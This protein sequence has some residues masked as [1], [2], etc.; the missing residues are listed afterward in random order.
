MTTRLKLAL[1]AS[2]ALFA[3]PALAQNQP[4]PPERYTIDANS[5]DLVT[6]QFLYFTQEAGIGSSG[7]G[8]LS[9]QRIYNRGWR[10]LN[11]GNIVV[12]GSTYRVAIGARTEVFTKSG[13][14]FTPKSNTGNTLTQSGGGF[15]Y[16]TSDGAVASFVT[17][18][19]GHMGAYDMG[20]VISTLS[21]PNGEMRT[22]NYREDV[23][24]RERN[25]FSGDCVDEI[26]LARLASITNNRGYALHYR[27]ANDNAQANPIT[28]L[29]FKG[30]ST[31]NRAYPS[32]IGQSASYNQST[33]T[34]VTDQDN[35]TTLYSYGAGNTLTLVR[36]PGETVGTMISYDSFGRVASVSGRQGAWT[37]AYTDTAT[38]RTT[39]ATG[40]LGQKVIVE[41]ALPSGLVST[42]TDALGRTL[43]YEYDAQERPTKITQPEG[44][45]ALLTYDARGNVTQTRYVAKPGTGLA[46][47][48]TSAVYPA[49]CANPVTCNQPTSTTDALGHT[50]NYTYDAAH[51]GVLTITAS[52]PA[53]GAARPQTR[54]AYAPQTGYIASGASWVPAGVPITLPVSVSECTTGT[55]CAGAANEVKTSIVYGAA[56]VANNL[57]PT[58]VTT[59]AGNGSLSATTTMTYTPN[60]DVASVN[61]PLA[62]TADTT[63]YR[64]NLARQLVGVVGPDPDGT[65]PLLR[66][67][68]RYTYNPRGQVTLAEAGT[69]TGTS[70]ANWA[71]FASLQKTAATY[72]AYGR[73]T[74]Q[75]QQ[76]GSTTH[77]L[78]QTSYDAAGRVDCVTTRMN[79]ATFA[80]PPTSACSAGTIGSFGPDRITKYGY[81]AASQLISTVSGF[82][83][84]SAAITERAAYSLNG[85]PISLTDGKGNVT[86]LIY[87]GFDRLA[88]MNYPNAMGGG[89]NI[90]DYELYSYNAA[91][92][93]LTYRNR[94]GNTFTAG[95]D[96]LGRQTSVTGGSMPARAYAYDNLG[97]LTSASITAG[98]SMT[99]T[100]DALDRLTS[101]TQNP[102]AKTVSYQ[103]DLA[104]RRTRLTWP[105][106]FFVNYDYNTVGDLTAIRENGATDWL[107][108]AWNYDNLG[109]RIA[110]NGSNG[111]K[112]SWTYDGAGR[113]SQLKHDLKDTAH[114]LTLA[115]GYNPAG[116]IVSRT[117]SNDIYSYP[118]GAG[119]VSYANNGRNQVTSV[120]GAA[121]AYDAR[122]NI[123][124]APAMGTYSYDNLNQMTSATVGGTA[125]SFAYDPAGRMS[126]MGASRLL[127]DGAQAVGEYNAAGT[128]TR[129]HIPGAGLDEV[130]VT[131]ND[132]TLT[133]R[134][135]AM[136]DERGSVIALTGA[137]AAGLNINTYDEYGQPGSGNTGLYQY[138]G[139]IW[140][141]QAQA[142]HYKARVY[143]PQLGRFMQTDPLGYTAGANLY[144]YVNGDPVNHVDP[145]GEIPHVIVGAGI[146][147]LFSAG[148]EAYGQ[149]KSGGEMNFKDI[150]VQGAI[151][152]AA[153]ATG[154]GV[155][156]YAGRILTSKIAAGALGGIAGG[157]AGGGASSGYSIFSRGG[158]TSE[159]ARAAGKGAAIGAIFGAVSGGA[160]AARPNV[161]PSL[162]QNSGY[163]IVQIQRRMR[164]GSA[165]AGSIIGEIGGNVIGSAYEI[166]QAPEI[167]DYSTVL[168]WM[169]M[170]EFYNGNRTC[171]LRMEGGG[172]IPCVMF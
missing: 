134:R 61:G 162:R 107:M 144:G 100:W 21:R 5:V 164:P 22:Y 31:Q 130:V 131:Y 39:T 155:G 54:I 38:K 112:S 116:Q 97:R 62:G 70:D 89:S 103:Y 71:A 6:G 168:D 67:A 26:R 12:S 139:Q 52:A 9:H 166:H 153:G 19:S 47:I 99:R 150:A 2:S 147:F 75:R 77:A 92:Q 146:G 126:Q 83:G 32:A 104:G 8:E 25:E 49:T 81:D 58:S 114:D 120:G 80:S 137:T 20:A 170:I 13:S 53:A 163:E 63:L 34:Q 1:L 46:D 94:G 64:Y 117:A 142:Y 74:H 69:V 108:V 111:A 76:S 14:T 28:W 121:V 161:A 88:R 101:E 45:H 41:A 98:G 82:G 129:R 87:D 57:L 68:E 11:I 30:A 123:T 172:F 127:Y 33:P 159:T 29:D 167:F 51:G 124:T 133:H 145:E 18:W 48:V 140:L 66:R 17:T 79:P 91:G 37:Y 44:D 40:P 138:T 59:G 118:P 160:L 141:P 151:G 90:N 105:D 125:T 84:G 152:A 113:L 132:A 72:D 50:T 23:Y 154:F 93:L 102:L 148:L 78:V 143:A 165:T 171:E 4:Q 86:T 27:Y 158:S 135:W 55:T 110:Q 109:R 156:A 73:P 3:T 106:G 56:N 119:T 95:Y 85:K 169:F 149:Y 35:Q 24:C 43:R 15:I 122:Q 128:L 115:F 36:R 96:A 136:M 42:V 16:R 7:N 65:G 10:D 60:G 157:G